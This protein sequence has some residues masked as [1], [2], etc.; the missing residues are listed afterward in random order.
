[1][2]NNKKANTNH[3]AHQVNVTGV[4]AH[5]NKKKYNRREKYNMDTDV[6]FTPHNMILYDLLEKIILD[7]PIILY[8]PKGH[9]VTAYV[10][11]IIG[12]VLTELEVYE[13]GSAEGYIKIGVDYNEEYEE[14]IEDAVEYIREL[15]E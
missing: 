2:K 14:A 6:L 5:K 15:R 10:D 12:T 13:I 1:M 8:S 3:I 9:I 11:E 4:G 7:T